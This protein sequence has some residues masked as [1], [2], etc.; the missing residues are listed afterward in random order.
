MVEAVGVEGGVSGV[1]RTAS[2][3]RRSFSAATCFSLSFVMTASRAAT[4]SNA[5]SSRKSAS[6]ASIIL[7]ECFARPCDAMKASRLY[8][9]AASAETAGCFDISSESAEPV[10]CCF[11]ASSEAWEESSII[12]VRCIPAHCVC[13]SGC[14]VFLPRRSGRISLSLAP[15]DMRKPS[16]A[17]EG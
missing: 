1:P 9:W 3:A 5:R 2:T 17:G 8:S 14:R 10:A 6:V 11:D 7:F 15:P 4:S 12:H 13:H 16:T